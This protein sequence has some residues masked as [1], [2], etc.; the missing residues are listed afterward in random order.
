MRVL[1]VA[2][3]ASGDAHA[4]K[5]ARHLLAGG[6]RVDAVGGDA[7]R[8]AGATLVASI[9]ELAVLGFVEV[10]Q[11]L[12]R[13]FALL[14]RLE[15]QLRAGAY[16]LLLTVDYPGFNLRLAGRARR[17]RIPV[18]HYIGPQVWAWRAHRL[19]VLRRVA[20]HVALVLP[21]ELPLYEA[22]KVPATYVGHPLLDDPEPAH[23]PD[24]DLGLFPGSRP[25]EIKQ[26]LP[27]L[28]DAW[29]RV[30]AARPEATFLVSRASTAP[31]GMMRDLLRARG[32]DPD[33][34]MSAA[35]AREVMARSRALLVASGT[36]TL[37]AALAARPFAVLYRTHALNYAVARH[38][39]RL[40][41]VALANLVAG[42]AV[43]REYLQDAA[44]P[45]ALATEALRLLSDAGE[46]TRQLQAWASVRE[47]LGPAGASQRVAAL[48]RSLGRG[49]SAGASS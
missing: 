15:A 20:S 43:V 47:R 45:A 21:F 5:V 1:I 10:A 7:L 3:E 33:A 41:Y 4:A 22:A 17:A 25:Q 48:A 13:L 32:H 29:E 26:H 12:P 34:C 31:E 42:Q 37:E 9:D 28:L 24:H 19:E 36:A 14:R 44:T 11:R 49:V 30:H 23:A 40:P 35:P 39:V 18:L 16:D 6:A 2:G 38:W 46:R 27:L 8:T